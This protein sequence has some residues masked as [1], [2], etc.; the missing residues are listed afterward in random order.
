MADLAGISEGAIYTWESGRTTPDPRH[1][2]RLATSLGITVRD[3]T[4]LTD[5]D[6]GLAELRVFAGLPLRALARDTSISP[7]TLNNIEIGHREPT[8]AQ[9]EVI[10]AALDITADRLRAV[11]RHVRAQRLADLHRRTHEH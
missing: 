8:N 1:L 6:I 5:D 11:W 9:A 7:S 10:G 2:H 3:F 4:N